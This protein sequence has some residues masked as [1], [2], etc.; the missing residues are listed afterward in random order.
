MS[1]SEQRRSRVQVRLL[2]EFMLVVDGNVV[3][4]GAWSRR[5]AASLVKVLALAPNKRLHREQVIDALWPEN[6]VDEAVPK[7]H[8]AAHYAR[9]A[10]GID[11]ALV[12]RDE[13]IALCPEHD[14]EVDVDHFEK[15]AQHALRSG[16]TS[17]GE[18]AL[19]RYT[20]ELLPENP[21]DEWTVERREHLR[22]LHLDLLRLLGRWEDLIELD[23]TDEEAHESLM[24]RHAANGNRHAALR[25]FERLEQRMRT[26]LGVGPRSSLLALRNELLAVVTSAPTPVGLIG[27]E[28]ELDTVGRLIDECATGAA[29][30]LFVQGAPGAGKTALL[31]EAISLAR[32][33]GFRVCRGFATS[34]QGAWPYS[35]VVEALA[36]L[37]RQHPTLLDGLADTHREEIERT[38]AGTEQG[39]SGNSSHQRLFLAAAELVRL[40]SST[41]A[42]LIALDDL[43][44]ADDASLRLVHYLA[45]SVVDQRVLFILSHRSGAQA[46]WLTEL[47]AGLIGRPDVFDL[48]LKPLTEEAIKELARTIADL[49]DTALDQIVQ[50]SDGIP[51]AVCELSRLAAR[52]P[53]WKMSLDTYIVARLRPDTRVALQRV[54]VIGSV[55][56][57]D[58][59]LV[60]SGLDEVTAY[61]AL[62]DALAR[63]VIEPASGG[64][65]F[66]HALVRDVLVRDLPPHR[67]RLIHVEAA[68]RLIEKGAS[69]ARIGH[70]LMGAGEHAAAVPYLLRAA[71][72]EAAIGAYRD[73][74][75]LVETI[76]PHVTGEERTR[77]L[78]LE[79]DLLNALG[80]SRAAAAYREA[81]EDAPE[82]V[83]PRL[84][85]RLARAAVM[86]DDLTTAAAALDGLEPNGDDDAE[87]LL[88]QAN[89]QFF[90][91]NYEEAAAIAEQ[92]QDLILSGHQNWMVLELVAL[93]GLLA[94][95]AGRWFDR[96]RLELRR[97]RSQPEIAN[98]IF[99]GHLCATE[100]MLYGPT[101]YAEVIQ[102][103]TDLKRT[104]RR[105]GALRAVAFA[106]TLLGESALLS[107]ELE[108]AGRELEEAVQLHQSVGSAAGEALSLQRLAEVRI[109]QGE[110][111]EARELLDQA[112][113][114]AR[115][116]N[117]ANH[118]M[119]RIFG[120]MVAAATDPFAARLTV[121]RAESILGW[122]ERCPFCSIM[123]AVP[124]T[125]ACAQAGDLD[126][127][128]RHLEVAE[129]SA[130]LWS[131]TAWEAALLEAR[132][133]VA[134]AEG[135]RA[136]AVD[137]LERAASG[138]E[139]CG[140]PLD[141]AR[142]RR[143]LASN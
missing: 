122:D 45:R 105:S 60:L 70:H 72:T 115:G 91:G 2:G 55:F 88:A 124:A 21:Y 81:L 40:A 28:R 12:V 90:S 92:A 31:D 65:R 35:T 87:I 126:H 26:E 123:F 106:S 43:H 51:F 76:R 129:Q 19:T 11:G 80:D 73:A 74:L 108:L 130:Q 30:V 137:L 94:H 143:L 139:R 59:F 3:P 102:L 66:R 63:R 125:S 132:A 5:H 41:S 133:A 93:Q 127:A 86:S 136:S 38:L 109:A 39:W 25:V 77:T 33:A 120:S 101:P 114:L 20:G 24:R 58:E 50:L 135:D 56:D 117:I 95:Y 79:G 97:T 116:S 134:R 47:R 23:P 53:A 121:D 44:D 112:L 61:A 138:F 48:E 49:D 64:Y 7:L 107:G 14:L 46:T 36:D 82:R 113:R 119:Q 13:H 104:A 75:Q 4:A 22:L 78:E 128:H 15:R 99:D 34:V 85:A 131:G 42:L 9:K 118:L 10:I 110:H 52:E 1:K 111:I 100:Y 18:D 29:R 16:D 71:E 103:A 83:I 68:R 57:T 141:A 69:P 32:N 142:C 54:A 140:Q 6:L 98:A 37:C 8:K 89:Y 17:I 62:D 27:R 67:H 96:I 84:R